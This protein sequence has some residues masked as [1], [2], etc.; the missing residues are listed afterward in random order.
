MTSHV[1]PS[2]PSQKAAPG[3]GR[4]R[5]FC[6]VRALDAA[7]QV[8]WRQGFEATS[9]DDLTAAMGVSRSSFYAAFG[10]KQ[11]VLVAALNSYSD[12]SLSVL[13]DMSN[14][15]PETRVADMLTALADPQ[16]GPR[17][18]LLVNCITEL[19]P[20]HDDIATIGRR[21]LERIEE[22]LAKALSP[23]HPDAVRDK[24]RA[25]AALA[26]GTLTLRKSGLPPE[27]ISRALEEGKA[28]LST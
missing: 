26:I 16:G 25:F 1:R 28:A 18:C 20:H 21:H 27:Q 22:L 19:A 7:L 5:S 10:S 9:L 15:A 14:G 23:E 4:P 12:A 8:F 3:P 17:G 24:A 6:E 2:Q 13:E 11:E